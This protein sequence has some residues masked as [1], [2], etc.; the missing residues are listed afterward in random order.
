[1]ATPTSES[2]IRS[3]ARGLTVIEAMGRSGEAHTVS[4]L[5][6]ATSLPRTVVRRIL[7]TLCELGYVATDEREFRLTPKILNLGMTYLTSLPFW[8]HAQRA[9]EDL[10]AQI[11]ESCALTV[12]DGNVVTYILRIPSR[13]ILSLRL[14]VG[15]RIPAY[16]TSPGRIAL[17]H[18]SAAALDTYL[19]DRQF[20]RYTPKTVDTAEH[21]LPLLAEVRQ[22]GYA[23][24]DGEYDESV[25]GLAVP[26]YDTQRNVVAA[27]NVN[28]LSR[29]IS[30]DK[31]VDTKLGPLLEAAHRLDGIA[32]AFLR[33]I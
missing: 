9:L 23:W 30:R 25:C 31:A 3:F 11:Q 29:Q 15:S 27:L 7:L 12:F 6:T 4:T 24:V 5:A 17:A 19:K 13:K 16:A 33:P 14:G 21:L 32:P 26:I 20:R 28:M 8:G 18:L 22:N 10:C 2:F 1:M